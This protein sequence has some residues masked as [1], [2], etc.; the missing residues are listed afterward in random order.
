MQ[1]EE[2]CFCDK[3]LLHLFSPTSCLLALPLALHHSPILPLC[4]DNFDLPPRT[5]LGAGKIIEGLD[6]G[7]LGMC[8]GEKR[9]VLVP[10]HLGHGEN[11]GKTG[12]TTG[13]RGKECSSIRI[14]QH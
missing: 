13:F 3:Y 2:K 4:R 6:T 5:T 8:V 12:E 9:D 14:A 1:R 10:P 7:L 11:G